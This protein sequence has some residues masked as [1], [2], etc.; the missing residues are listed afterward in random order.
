MFSA[1]VDNETSPTLPITA[2]PRS[3][4]RKSAQ[5]VS[6]RIRKQLWVQRASHPF[7]FFIALI[8]QLMYYPGRFMSTKASLSV[9]SGIFWTTSRTWA[10]TERTSLFHPKGN[11][12][13]AV[14]MMRMMMVGKRR[15]RWIA[16]MRCWLKRA[17][18]LRQVVVL[19]ARSRELAPPPERCE[20]LQTGRY[21]SCKHLQQT[22]CFHRVLLFSH[23]VSFNFLSR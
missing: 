13:A 1:E 9:R 7:A 17:D 12:R 22:E 6:S 18:M 23:L 3:L 2:T 4:K 11:S 21:K 14:R 20:E 5:L 19:L 10:Q 8:N 16:M 15:Q